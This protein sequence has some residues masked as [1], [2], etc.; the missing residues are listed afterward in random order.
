[1]ADTLEPIAADLWTAGPEPHLIGG[2]LP[3]GKI[4]FPLPEGDAAE[5]V[6]PYALSRTGTLWSWTRQD[7]RPKEPY[8]GSEAFEPYLIG[9]VEL[10]GEVIVETR[11]ADATL[12][13]LSLGMPMEFV[14][15]PFDDT[16]STYAY[17]PEKKA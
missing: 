13:E 1:M 7:F 6:E 4:V 12:E 17:R 2:R 14:I 8:E 11:I 5:D 3:D 16:R 15:V 10:P 9:Y